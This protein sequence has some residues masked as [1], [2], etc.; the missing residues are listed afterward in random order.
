MTR[1]SAGVA[2]ATVLYRPDPALLDALL[3]VLEADGLPLF[4]FVNGPVEAGVEARLAGL[5]RATLLRSPGNIGLGAGLNAVVEAAQAQGFSH[6]LLFD[7]DSTPAAGLAAALLAQWP[8]AERVHG[9]V[10]A[11]GPVLTPPPGESFLPIRYHRRAGLSDAA[12]GAVDF[13]PT[14]GTLVSISAWC[15]VGPFRA[16]YFVDGIDVE[17][18]FRAWSRGQACLLAE[19]VAMSH[20]WGHA[21]DEAGRL[22]QILRQSRLRSYYYLRNASH[23][24]RLA[25]FPFGWKIKATLRLLAQAGLL[26]MRGGAPLEM[27]PLVGRAF[28]DGLGGRLGPAPSAE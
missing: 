4:V 10:A 25:H 19:Q 17:W 21:E 13:L 24:L 14:S 9:V 23:G 12:L 7:Q 18:C 27:L 2:A 15:E 3:A 22:P 5:A 11:I 28:R 20:R 26:V 1:P 8:A 16:D 6:I